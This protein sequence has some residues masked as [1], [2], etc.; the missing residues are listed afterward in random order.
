MS[1]DDFAN[2][3]KSLLMHYRIKSI[4]DIVHVLRQILELSL[5]TSQE[6]RI[7]K[8][9]VYATEQGLELMEKRKWSVRQEAATFL[10]RWWRLKLKKRN[11]A[12]TVLQRWWRALRQE[13]AATKIQCWWLKK[14]AVL[15]M[16]RRLT[17]L[18]NSIRVV[19]R[20]L[21]R[22]IYRRKL[23]ASIQSKRKVRA[24]AIVPP[25]PPRIPEVVPEIPEVDVMKKPPTRNY[26]PGLTL[27]LPRAVF[28]FQDGVISIRQPPVV[29]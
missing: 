14:R 19:K 1:H 12:A 17:K 9:Q 20:V 10:Q 5:G 28:F 6:V 23:V 22:W 21:K 2:R 8:N 27:Q 18:A 16:R 13:K 3:Y 24:V 29:I 11:R 15:Q 25:L 4:P 7:G 26:C